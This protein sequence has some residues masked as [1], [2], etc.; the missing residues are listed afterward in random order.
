MSA[1]I[2]GVIL[3]I[4]L[5]V[6]VLYHDRL[7]QRRHGTAP[8]L[9]EPRAERKLVGIQIICGNCAGDEAR[10]RRTYLSEFETCVQ[11]GGDSF[12]LASNI[13]RPTVTTAQAEPE[14]VVFDPKEAVRKYREGRPASPW[15]N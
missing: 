12:V 13:Y 11:C 5:T 9:N 10:P 2:C 6:L 4:A 8:C 15:M 14:R 7:S 3:S 1:L